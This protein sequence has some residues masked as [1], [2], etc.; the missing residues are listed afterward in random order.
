[1]KDAS[2]AMLKETENA[3]KQAATAGADEQASRF[4]L[5]RMAET[6]VDLQQARNK[7]DYDIGEPFRPLDAAVYV[8]QARL[9]FVAWAEVRDEP[10]AHRYLYSLLVRDRA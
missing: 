8:A 6:F 1:M 3:P 4:R 9:A 7:A 10:L 5:S 2:T